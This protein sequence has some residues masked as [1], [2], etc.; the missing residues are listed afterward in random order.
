MLW[1]PCIFGPFFSGV[2]MTILSGN[3]GN[4]FL[5]KC[6]GK[7]SVNEFKNCIS[8][9]SNPFIRGISLDS[10]KQATFLTNMTP[11]QIIFPEDGSVGLRNLH[12]PTFSLNPLLVYRLCLYD[13]DYL[14]TISNPF[15][16]PRT[17]VTVSANSSVIRIPVKVGVSFKGKR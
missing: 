15:I 1:T 12:N 8:Q 16:I 6:L 13:K 4:G 9:K 5:S 10:Y 7:N 14:L 17:C 11:A 3:G 2:F